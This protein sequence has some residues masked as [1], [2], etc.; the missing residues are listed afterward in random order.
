MISKKI[1]NFSKYF[2]LNKKNYLDGKNLIEDFVNN[3]Y[4]ESLLINLAEIDPY[5]PKISNEFLNL[6]A[7]SCLLY[8][9][10][11]ADE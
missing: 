2:I 3:N 10:D 7:I 1:S 6:D 4:F 11:A 9:S 8:T 5:D